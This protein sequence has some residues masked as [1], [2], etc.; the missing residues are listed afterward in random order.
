MLYCRALK[1]SV[2]ISDACTVCVIYCGLFKSPWAQKI[3][4]FLFSIERKSGGTKPLNYIPNGGGLIFF[5]NDFTIVTLWW[6]YFTILWCNSFFG[7]ISLYDK[8]RQCA[9]KQRHYSANKV[10]YSQDYGLPSGHIELW[11]LDC[12]EGRMPKN[13]CFWTLVQ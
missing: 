7:R 10:L 6:Y 12:K 9:E 3:I 1:E 4:L 13:W 11:L 8:P 5:L 2:D